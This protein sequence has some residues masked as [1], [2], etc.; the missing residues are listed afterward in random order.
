MCVLCPRA[1]RFV[2]LSF[3]TLFCRFFVFRSHRICFEFLQCVCNR[4]AFSDSIN[5]QM[6]AACVTLPD[7][8]GSTLAGT[9]RATT[10]TMMMMSMTCR[11]HL[12]SHRKH[13]RVAQFCATIYGIALEWPTDECALLLL[14]FLSTY[15]RSERT[16]MELTVHRFATRH[17]LNERKSMGRKKECWLASGHF[18]EFRLLLQ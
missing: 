10:T 9:Q 14:A 4:N 17:A 13:G 3:R 7:V 8:Y 15:I 11:W 2:I 16:T 12:P 6:K 1:S 5:A 18:L